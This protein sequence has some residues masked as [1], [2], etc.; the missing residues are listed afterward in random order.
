[1]KQVFFVR[2]ILVDCEWGTVDERSK[3]LEDH[4]GELRMKQVIFLR[5][6]LVIAMIMVSIMKLMTTTMI[7][8]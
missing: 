5:V 3:L 2:I 4:L 6:V 8:S 7:T 1:M